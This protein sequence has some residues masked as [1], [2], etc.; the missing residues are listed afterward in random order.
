MLI[1]GLIISGPTALEFFDRTQFPNSHLELYVEHRLRRPIV[2]LLQSFD[3]KFLPRPGLGPQNVE[4]LLKNEEEPALDP[5]PLGLLLQ[6]VKKD[7]YQQIKITT[8]FASP[9]ATVLFLHS[10]K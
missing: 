9:L 7:S 8:S 4:E 5:W 1:I 3:Y 6:F 2:C 10:C